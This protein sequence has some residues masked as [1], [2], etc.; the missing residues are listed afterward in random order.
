M[1]RMNGFILTAKIREDRKLSELPVVLVTGVGIKGGSGTG[2]RCRRERLYR[3]EQFRPEQSAGRHQEAG[4]MAMDRRDRRVI[5]VLI[6]DDSPVVRELLTH[7]LGSD[8]EIQVVG[9]AENGAVAVEMRLAALR[10]MSSPWTFACLSWAE[11]EA[12]RRI[13]EGS[14]RSRGR[15]V[16]PASTVKEVGG[17]VSRDRGRSA[18]HPQESGRHRPP[19]PRETGP[20]IDPHGETHVRGQGSPKVAPRGGWRGSPGELSSGADSVQL[21][22]LRSRW[23]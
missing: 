4:L 15:R 8:P 23:W 11:Y 9:T 22:P 16:R 21:E 6:V 17:F 5:R 3:E 2:N 12:T 10:P 13:N 19:G 1:P 20:G 14:S 7:I 18:D